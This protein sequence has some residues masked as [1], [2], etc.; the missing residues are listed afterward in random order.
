MFGQMRDII[1]ARTGPDGRVLLDLNMMESALAALCNV[2][3]NR[4]GHRHLD[5]FT[6]FFGFVR[7]CQENSW[8][9]FCVL[10]D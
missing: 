1:N 3:N 6:T 10:L 4:S 8:T 9:A 2:L 7:V 5:Y